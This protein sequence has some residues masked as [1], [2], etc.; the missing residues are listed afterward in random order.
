MLQPARQA[1][2]HHGLA[3]P[4]AELD[5]AGITAPARARLALGLVGFRQFSMN[6][7]RTDTCATSGAPSDRTRM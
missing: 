7:K 2:E 3:G 4:V 6:G 1:A 5:R